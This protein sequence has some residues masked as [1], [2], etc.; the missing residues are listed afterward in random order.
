MY[1][2]E[3][4]YDIHVYLVDAMRRIL[5]SCLWMQLVQYK[6]SCF[7]VLHARLLTAL[8]TMHR[9][10]TPGTE[11]CLEFMNTSLDDLSTYL[12]RPSVNPN[13]VG[14]GNQ[15]P[16][17]STASFWESIGDL[18]VPSHVRGFLR[19]QQQAPTPKH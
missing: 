4:K 14:T 19:E 18:A 17:W 13:D 5:I 2:Q 7:K 9:R 10:A 11:A 1:K 6:I 3:T 15:I 8:M 12:K 16:K